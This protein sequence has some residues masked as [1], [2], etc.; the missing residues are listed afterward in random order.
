MRALAN[1]SPSAVMI[2]F[3][4]TTATKL[5]QNLIARLGYYRPSRESLCTEDVLAGADKTALL[6]KTSA[7]RLHMT[8]QNVLLVA[9]PHPSQSAYPQRSGGVE[10]RK[11]CAHRERRPMLT[12]APE[13][14]PVHTNSLLRSPKVMIRSRI[15]SCDWVTTDQAASV[16]KDVVVTAAALGKKT[17]YFDNHSIT[18]ARVEDSTPVASRLPRLQ[19]QIA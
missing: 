17:L 7:L 3:C 12:R 10:A 18:R 19:A 5:T 14:M 1:I 15:S 8:K 2:E 6:T 11:Q 9:E 16:Y 4:T 13:T